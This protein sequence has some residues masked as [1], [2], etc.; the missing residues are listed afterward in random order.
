MSLRQC[1]PSFSFAASPARGEAFRS[2]RLSRD[3]RSYHF[4]HCPISTFASRLRQR[5]LGPE[6]GEQHQRRE[7]RRHWPSQSSTTKRTALAT[8]SALANTIV[9]GESETAR[10]DHFDC[11]SDGWLARR[12]REGVRWDEKEKV[13]SDRSTVFFHA[14]SLLSFERGEALG[15][16]FSTCF[17]EVQVYNM[18]KR[19]TKRCARSSSTP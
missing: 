5:S 6:K 16:F 4:I 14:T 2:N 1:F 15:S 12:G 17:R 11:R 3:W 13:A 9:H 18:V 10:H 7:D 19:R 8:A